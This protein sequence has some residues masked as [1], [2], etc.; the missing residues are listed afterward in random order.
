[1]AALWALSALLRPAFC[2]I[3]VRTLNRIKV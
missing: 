1:M 2:G 3:A